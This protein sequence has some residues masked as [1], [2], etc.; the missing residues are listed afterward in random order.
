[1]DRAPGLSIRLKLTLSYAGIL[2][3]AGAL[4]LAAVWVFLLR[5]V[6]DGSPGGLAPNRLLIRGDALVALRVFWGAF[7]PAAAIVLA[8]L[9][10]FGLLGGVA[11]RRPDARPADPHHRRHANGR[12]RIALPPNPATGSKR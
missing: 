8:F 10:L 4:L 3:L 2:M 5:Y 6:P 9:L 7:A 12:E 11:S 1:V